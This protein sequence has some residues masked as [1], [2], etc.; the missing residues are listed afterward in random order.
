MSVR[1]FVQASVVVSA[2]ATGNAVVSQS[3][4]LSS[5][6]DLLGDLS[7]KI[8]KE[9]EVEA[10]TFKE[11]SEWCD[12]TV[13]D[14]NFEIKTAASEK[15]KLE[16]KIS[17]L[18]GN[19]EES[20]SKVSDLAAAIGTATKELESATAIRKKEAVE[21][22]TSEKELL[23]VVDTLGR[24]SSV[25]QREMQ[26]SPASFAQLTRAG[27]PTVLKSLSA[28]GDAAAFSAVDQK[29]LLA[30]V[31]S[32]NEASEGDGEG[33][34]G[35]PAAAVYESHSSSIF[36][37][38]DDMKEKAEEQ[39]SSLR[40]AEVNAKHN[41]GMLK[42]GLEDQL[43]ADNK[44]MDAEKAAKASAEEGK[45]TAEGDLSATVADLKAT[46]VSLAET[47]ST[48]KQVAAD[49]SATVKAREEELKVIAEAVDILKSSTSGAKS[50]TYSLL[51]VAT[52]RSHESRVL[53]WVKN[54]A[55]QHHSSALAQL[56]SRIAAVASRSGTEPFAKVKGLISDLI[57]KLE[58]EAGAEATE[59]AFCD[60]EMSKTTAK[61][62]ELDTD[63]SK[64]TTKIDQA[65]ARSNE[66]KEEVR[67]LQKDVASM[68]KEQAE[69]NKIREETHANYVAAKADLEQGLS[70]VRKAL[71]VLR[72][73]YAAKDD[74]GAALLQ[75]EGTQPAMP[76]KFEASKGA[77]TSIIG[78]LEVAESDFAKNLA[79]EETAEATAQEEYEKLT[80]DNK[81]S[82][83][84]KDQDVEYKNAEITSL[85]KTVS[86]LSTDLESTNEE[87]AAV[88]EYDGKLKERCV[89]KPESYEERVK[90]RQ[91]EIG[92]LKEALSILQEEAL[93]QRGSTRRK[94]NMRG[95][96][97]LHA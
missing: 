59:K 25:L 53:K 32:R 66:L 93:L 72:D 17:E 76:Q 37:V 27:L 57:S 63:V 15:E 23:D 80:E 50:K 13:T 42:Q 5:V 95:A 4:P 82:T 87:L 97:S 84:A 7:A 54:L 81:V 85:A 45:S 24:A 2:A 88:V 33:E 90:R 35:A 26:K 49:H 52:D 1:S 18:T 73:Y 55:R 6:L 94:S 36:D 61:K 96:L 20:E 31:Q 47:S 70:G 67:Q 19:I 10:Q 30:L 86:E 68:A 8:T 21:F 83:A 79:H 41:F 14:K 58:A 40:K 91:A 22:A 48:C 29:R 74:E 77:G 38:L 16:A 75:S 56:A 78:I 51:Q 28:V 44:D 69:A 12:D 3:N 71:V 60:E 92:G 11:Y 62:D 46:K 9:G 64:L 34:L 43:A 65:N 89:A 39:L